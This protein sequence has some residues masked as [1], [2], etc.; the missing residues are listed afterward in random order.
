MTVSK[1]R[2]FTVD[3]EVPKIY[4]N[5]CIWQIKRKTKPYG[6]RQTFC[7]CPRYAE[8]TSDSIVYP[9]TYEINITNYCNNFYKKDSFK[10]K[11]QK[12]IWE[13]QAKFNLG[14]NADDEDF[15]D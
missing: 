12:K 6:T 8:D 3:G 10:E 14:E 7:T 5:N 15:L 1:T 13:I 2:V 9:N 11:I 4:C